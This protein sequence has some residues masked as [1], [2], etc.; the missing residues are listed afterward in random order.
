MKNL[1]ALSLLIITII[2]CVETLNGQSKK[3]GLGIYTGISIN[4]VYDHIQDERF[5]SQLSRKLIGGYLEYRLIRRLDIYAE[6]EY[7]HKGPQNFKIDYHTFSL[8]GKYQCFRYL[9][10]SIMAGYYHGFLNEYLWL[11]RAWSHP[12]LKDYDKGIEF[13]LMYEQDI[14]KKLGLFIS[15]R[16]E[17]GLIQFSL[18]KH[19][20][21]QLKTGIQF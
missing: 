18:S 14:F 2:C 1:L 11:G 12:E 10:I 3:I 15:P 5:E 19:I 6:F 4:N 16:I 9:D 8:M 7:V 17:I 13:G 20:S 21:Y